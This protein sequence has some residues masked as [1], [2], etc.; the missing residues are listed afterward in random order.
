MYLY[1]PAAV[2]VTFAACGSGTS[3]EPAVS[4][5]ARNPLPW[6]LPS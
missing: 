3:G 6:F 2:N 4:G 5:V 1:V